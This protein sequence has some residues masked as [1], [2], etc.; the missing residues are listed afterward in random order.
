[1]NP[2]DHFCAWTLKF[3]WFLPLSRL[4]HFR[5]NLNLFKI[6]FSILF[7]VLNSVFCSKT[8]TRDKFQR[9][10]LDSHLRMVLGKQY[11][12]VHGRDTAKRMNCVDSSYKTAS[13]TT[14]LKRGLSMLVI[15]LLG[16]IWKDPKYFV[17]LLSILLTRLGHHFY[18]ALTMALN[19]LISNSGY[20]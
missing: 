20:F 9:F 6:R 18:T 10:W 15:M 19:K 12:G 17:T 7:Y 8:A 13:T 16:I 11:N 5:R 2:L 4:R 1:M 14:C 3:W